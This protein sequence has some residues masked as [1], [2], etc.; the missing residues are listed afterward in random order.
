M[1]GLMKHA[2]GWQVIQIAGLL[3]AIALCSGLSGCASIS[4]STIPQ[5]GRLYD[6]IAEAK[7][8]RH[9]LIDNWVELWEDFIDLR[10]YEVWFIEYVGDLADDTGIAD[11]LCANG[12]ISSLDSRRDLRDFSVAASDEYL[13][14]QSARLKIL[15]KATR[16]LRRETDTH[17]DGLLQMTTAI[18]TNLEAVEDSKALQREIAQKIAPKAVAA[19]DAANATMDKALKEI[20]N[21]ENKTKK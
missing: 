8:T 7:K 6:G 9:V 14:R 1:G 4:P 11:D 12:K 10:L 19:F 15:R 20:E 18:K 17:Y 5:A 21:V 13:K 3:F 2:H 16:K